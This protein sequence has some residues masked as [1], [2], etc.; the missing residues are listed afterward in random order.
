VVVA[1]GELRPPVAALD[2]AGTLVPAWAVPN[3]DGFTLR[4]HESHGQ[5][6]SAVLHLADRRA[7]VAYVDLLGNT[8]GKPQRL[9][10][11]QYRLDYTPH[12]VLSIH[13]TG[14]QHQ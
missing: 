2:D 4:L 14:V 5:R 6:G 1:G 7:E 3:G 13:V 8:R 12:Q 9:A 11:G 10:P